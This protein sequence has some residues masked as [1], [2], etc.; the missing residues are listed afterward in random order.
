MAECFEQLHFA[1]RCTVA[2]GFHGLSRR[3]GSHKQRQIRIKIAFQ[4][5]GYQSK[6]GITG[7]DFI[8][9]FGSKG[10]AVIKLIFF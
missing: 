2:D 9:Y 8:Y 10:G 4:R 3:Q 5:A 1:H 7:A 6:H